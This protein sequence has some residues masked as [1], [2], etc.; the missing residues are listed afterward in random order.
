M[1]D[2]AAATAYSRLVSAYRRL[3]LNYRLEFAD[4]IKYLE[5]FVPDWGR[6]SSL[7]RLGRY[8]RPPS[9]TGCERNLGSHLEANQFMTS[10]KAAVLIGGLIDAWDA[11]NEGYAALAAADRNNLP[12]PAEV[13]WE[14]LCGTLSM[15]GKPRGAVGG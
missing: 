14:G 3:L 7:A 10:D 13:H 2:E 9:A 11:L 6:V 1:K 4:A 12:A 5:G 8:G 15:S